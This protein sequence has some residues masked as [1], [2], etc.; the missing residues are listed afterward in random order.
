MKTR[1]S[2]TP[3]LLASV[4]LI[5]SFTFTA[6]GHDAAAPHKTAA[7]T[8]AGKLIPVGEKD[9]A[10]AAQ[11]RKSYPLEVCVTSDEKLGSMGKSP[12]YIYRVDGKP[13]RLVVFCCD[14]CEEDFLKD[15]AKYLTKIDAAAK[16]K[17]SPAPKADAPKGHGE[18]KH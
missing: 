6:N 2:L 17:S 1:S 18:H 9:A 8:T 15:P 3:A 11:A 7:A 16:A 4:L 10:W 5:T 14:G 13:D 12:E